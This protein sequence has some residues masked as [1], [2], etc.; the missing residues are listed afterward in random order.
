MRFGD[1]SQEVL[2]LT[3]SFTG[4]RPILE[5]GNHY[6]SASDSLRQP[7][8]GNEEGWG[9]LSP[10]RYDFTPCFVDIWIFVVAAFGLVGGP[11]AI[12]YV[13]RKQKTVAVCKDWHFWTKQ[14]L[15]VLIIADI[16]VQ[17]V[18]QILNFPGVWFGDF[19]FLTTLVTL[20][21]LGVI[22]TAQWLEHN[23]SR[24]ANGVVLFFWLLLLIAYTIKLRS[25]VSQQLYEKNVAYFITYTVGFGL[26]VLEFL[27]E[28]L[29]PKRAS[30]YDVLID[31]DGVECPVEYATIFSRL[32]FS[33]MTPM[34]KF[35]YKQ[36][37]TEEDLWGLSRDTT[38]R[39]TGD[40]FDRAW[41]YELAHRGKPSLWLALFKAYGGP[42]LTATVFKF[43]NDLSAFTQPQ[44]LRY[45]ISFVDSYRPS[46]VPQPPIKGAAIAIAMFLVATLQT[47]MVHQYFQL[48]FVT[49]MHIKSGLISAIYKKS[50]KLSN[51]GRSTKTTGDIVNYMAVDAQR[52]QDLT[53]FAQQVWSAPF[54]IILCMISLYQLVGWSMLSGIGVMLIMIPINGFI[55]RFMKR[56][57]K[58][59]MKNK[60]SRSRLIAE[61]VNNM[62]SIKLYAWSTAFMNKLNFVRNDLELRNLRKI[63]AGQAFAN[64]TWSTTPFLVS[65][66]TFAIFVWTHDVPLSTEIV[67]PAL[68][69]FNLLTFPLAVLPMVITSIIEAT[70]AA[71][72]LSQ[73]LLA[74]EIQP[75]AVEIG[76][77]AEER[78][79]DAVV[80]RNGTF[81]WNRHEMKTVLK[82]IDFTAH[83]G[84]LHCIVGRVGQ[85]KSSLLQ[86]ILGDLWKVEGEV[87]MNGTVAY[88]AQQPWIMNATVK[89][90]IVFGHRYDSNFYE[91][92]VKACALLDDFAQLPDGDETVV[93]ERGI[94]LSGGQKARVALARAV[95]ARADIYLL[96]DCLSAVDSHVAR[97][98]VENVLG[99]RG[100]LNSKCRI[101]AT[102]AIAVLSDAD[103]ISQLKEG[104]IVESG[105]FR[106]LVAMKGGIAELI[107]S[108]GQDSGSS[109]SVGGSSGFG[110]D[111]FESETSTYIE[112]DAH[113]DKEEIEEAQEGLAELAPIKTGASSSAQNRRGS[114][115][116]LRRASAAS[117]RGPR[118]KLGD[119]EDPSARTRQTKEHLEQGK[120]KWDVYLEYAK[121]SN[122]VAVGVYLLA[123]IAAQTGQIGGSVW[124]KTWAERNS[125]VGGN[126]DVGKYLGIYFAFGVG[127]AALTVVQTLIL[128]IFCSIEASRKLHER[129][130]TAI[131]RA[132]MSF[133]NTTPAGRILNRFSSDI[134]RLDEILARTFNMLFV[135][136]ARSGFTL[137]VISVGTPAFVALIIP[138]G[139]VYYW[140]QRYYLRTSRELKRLDSV[141]RSPMY[142]HFQESLGG[143]STIR[144][145]R[146]QERFEQ[147]NQYRVDSNLRAYYPSISA[148][149]WLAVRLEFL[150]AVIILG[151][152]GFAVVS[153]TNHSGLGPGMVGLTM[154]YALQITT[155]LNWIVRQTVEVETNIVSVERIL[156]YAR[157]PSEAPEIIPRHRPPVAWPANGTVDFRNFSARYREGLDLVLKNINLDIKSHEKIGVVGRTGAG[158]SSLTLALFRLIEADTGQINIDDLNTSTIG[159][160]DL[161]RRLAIIPQDAALF[162]GTIR[163]NLDPGHVHDD[164]ELW[165]VLDH[166]RLKEHVVN[167]EG[168][169][170]AKIHE[171][172]SNLSAG[173]RQLISLARAMLT[174]SN[175]LV[176]DEATA[177]VDVETDAMLQTTLRSDIFSHRTII[178]VAHRINTILD[179]DRVVVLDKGE[180]AE[181]DTPQALIKKKG[182][183]YS[184]VKQS[185]LDAE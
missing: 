141:S 2:Q 11:L 120:V 131:F 157:L 69:L 99:P 121:T 90:N 184:L 74:E 87:R 38:T 139:A 180:V 55:A 158:K 44:L 28:W 144:A 43:V 48:A 41:Q 142:A 97:H 63:G 123:L 82:G 178:T 61:I 164:T 51:E 23:R 89:E 108:S 114:M 6:L 124:L 77:A 115:A 10:F 20:I 67:F 79:D 140:V 163:D 14:S 102:N 57:Q 80:I 122:L 118:G 136:F 117:F 125:A 129:M 183:F 40:R 19:R 49:G 56:L 85:G 12:W 96:D 46:N 181:F 150:G 8:C 156:E 175:I 143:I 179:S 88:V 162:E 16:A 30:A 75:E 50:L 119:E 81:S 25:L 130:A 177:A 47:T 27:F 135:N 62:K 1:Q 29:W 167:M 7:L 9:P 36:F 39:G 70:V 71:Q 60:D 173:Q 42:Y 4:Y 15:L 109:S 3:G 161:R 148:N 76:P 21:S 64:F 133:F 147:E 59:Q 72:R 154:S 182:I 176:L 5:L 155:S 138:L 153:V 128:W 66:S 98:I 65:C 100:L 17:L 13:L 84:D 169:L 105:T 32:T 95:Y 73:Y 127:S 112:P 110:P 137:I 172:G 26:S 168:G 35:G 170:E 24:N 126:P 83:K 33:W 165:S 52:L 107:K 91:K 31:E 151:A 37:L 171:G 68:A 93:G 53:Q 149:R 34:M 132:P 145:Y 134:Y 58:Q 94:S 159:L 174:P 166:A 106:Q 78:G 54:Q 45:L 116:T 146:Q 185:G 22:F 92:T 101:L 104:E 103:F 160:L 113:Q 111:R 86:S 18:I 152:A